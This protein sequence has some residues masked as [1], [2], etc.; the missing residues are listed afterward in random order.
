MKLS[1]TEKSHLLSIEKGYAGE[2]LFDTYTDQLSDRW[3]T[4]GDLLLE[5]NQNPFQM[6]S[7]V[8]NSEKLYLFDVKNFE[9][10]YII[11][12]D[13]RWFSKFSSNE[14]KDPLE[15]LRR[16]ESLLRRL[17]HD[18]GYK[19][20]IEAY[21]IF[22]NPEFHLYNASMNL[23]IIYPSQLNRFIKNL[24]TSRGSSKDR[25]PD[26]FQRLLSLNKPYINRNRLPVYT[27]ESLFKGNFCFHCHELL[28]E[29]VGELLVCKC[30]RTEDVATAIIRNIDE[31]RLLF[32][33]KKITTNDMFEWCGKIKS[34]KA[35]RRILKLRF[36]QVGYGRHV[37]FID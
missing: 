20:P 14:I 18:L 8:R 11:D 19:F 28:T 2:L 24:C 32:P 10:D 5:F 29:C 9:G 17:L 25:Y 31:Y 34:P 7:L 1:D 26:L 30:G 6:D 27:F 21:L 15:Q 22:V 37:H 33:D 3:Q 4:M 36:K 16:C 13:G 35:I 12:K 23:P